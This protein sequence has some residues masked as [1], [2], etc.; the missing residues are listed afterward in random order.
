M[1]NHT[2]MTA[3]FLL[4]AGIVCCT[5]KAI[6]QKA[7]RHETT[8]DMVLSLIDNL[9]EFKKADAYYNKQT[10]GKKHLINMLMND[11]GNEQGHY[12]LVR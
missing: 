8:Q 7:S 1:E 5:H 11:K 2:L 10:H 6:G 4:I 3:G 9:P 12:Y